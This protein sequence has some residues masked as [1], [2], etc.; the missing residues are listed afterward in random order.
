ME[1]KTLVGIVIL[2]LLVSALYAQVATTTIEKIEAN[3]GSYF[4]KEV[5]V[6]GFIE[7][8][9]DS[10]G[11]T[12]YYLL[13]GDYGGVIKVN[14]SKQEETK[15]KYY[16]TGLVQ[17]DLKTTQPIIVET[18]IIPVIPIPA[19]E[20]PIV[21]YTW[22]YYVFGGL[23]IVLI[24]LIIVQFAIKK[25]GKMEQTLSTSSDSFSS[26]LKAPPTMPSQNTM[27]RTSSQFSTI[28]ITNAV[29]KTMRFIPGKLKIVSDRDKGK[30][31]RIAGYPTPKGNI[32]TI[33]REAVKGDR[34]FAHIQI[35]EKFGTVSRK[36]AEFREKDGKLYIK[37][38]SSTNLTQIN[39]KEIAA[40]EIVEV[41]FGD[42]VRMGEIEFEYSM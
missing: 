21:D 18:K 7:L 36:Q 4:G 24:I 15:K 2:V 6:L 30:E 3:P 10:P 5:T 8:Y 26:E 17:K 25:K 16:V 1:K 9:V 33:G 32:V 29:P 13:K 28:K 38:L 11:G 39:G 40:N 35:D 20:E 22:I 19:E 31:F 27:P 14:C 41:K 34:E 42:V 23:V 37:N 12:Y